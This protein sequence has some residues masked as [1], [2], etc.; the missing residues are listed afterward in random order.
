M[1]DEL[2]FLIKPLDTARTGHRFPRALIVFLR[3]T[4]NSPKGSETAFAGRGRRNTKRYP[5]NLLIGR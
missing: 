1:N 2:V 3:L 4:G 5:A